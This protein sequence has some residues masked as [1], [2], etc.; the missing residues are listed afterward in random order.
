MDITGLIL[1][2]GKSSRMGTDK[3]L[4]LFGKQPLVSYSITLVQQICK[5]IYISTANKD[6]EQFNH[7]LISDIIPDIGPIGG[8]YSALNKIDSNYFFVLSCDIPYALLTIAELLL[9]YIHDYEIVVP[10]WGNSKI[11]PLFG[12]YSKSILPA[13]KNQIDNKNFKMIDLLKECKTF[14]LNVDSET[15]GTLTFKNINTPGDA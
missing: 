5:N 4:V 11:E 14:Y 8:I 13:L 3:G 2:G 1:A 12:F 9:K 15:E 6:Y 10:V 7:E